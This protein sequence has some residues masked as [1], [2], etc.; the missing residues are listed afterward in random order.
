MNWLF[1]KQGSRRTF[2][3][4]TN[5][6]AAPALSRAMTSPMTIG[7]NATYRRA[8]GGGRA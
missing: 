1:S 2:Q 3:C 7:A 8:L 5:F 4:S 6:T